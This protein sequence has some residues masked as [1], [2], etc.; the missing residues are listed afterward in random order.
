M[1]GWSIAFLTVAIIA[2]IFGFFG[3]IGTTAWI[4]KVLFFIGLTVF[5]LLLIVG[6]RPPSV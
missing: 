3:V 6:R 5:L 2:G 4:A 1:F